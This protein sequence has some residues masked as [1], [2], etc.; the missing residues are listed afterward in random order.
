[1]I[2][3]GCRVNPPRA[4][5]WEQLSWMIL[6]WASQEVTGKLAGGLQS[7]K[8]LQAH[9][10]QSLLA[11]GLRAPPHGPLHRAARGVASLRWEPQSFY[12]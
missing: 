4:G 7:G 1:M 12:T 2:S 5:V 3:Q 9:A 8:G 6:A 11:G 10:Y